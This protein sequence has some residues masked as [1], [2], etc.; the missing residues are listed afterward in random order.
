MPAYYLCRKKSKG[1]KKLTGHLIVDFVQC[2]PP[3]LS[4]GLELVKFFLSSGSLYLDFGMQ[5]LVFFS[6]Y[7]G[8]RKGGAYLLNIILVFLLQSFKLLLQPGYFITFLLQLGLIFL[9]LLG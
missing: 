8:L 6:L 7:G 4:L 5:I 9:L 3:C 1:K 2:R